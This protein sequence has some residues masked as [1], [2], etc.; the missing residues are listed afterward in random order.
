L[1]GNFE[2]EGEEEEAKRTPP[3]RKKGRRFT[4][5][6]TREDVLA[7]LYSRKRGKGILAGRKGVPCRRQ[8]ERWEKEH[9][10]WRE[11]NNI[12]LIS[13]ERGGSAFLRIKIRRR[14]DPR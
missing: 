4:P 9:S 6:L 8:L 7:H 5:R 1:R 12:D 10:L 2:Q 3:Q 11:A 14:R 13:G